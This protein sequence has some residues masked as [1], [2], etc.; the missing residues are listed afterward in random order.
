MITVKKGVCKIDGDLEEITA[1]ML[2][3]MKSLTELMREYPEISKFLITGDAQTI[4]DFVN[5][6]HKG[7]KVNL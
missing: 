4:T 3:T 7:V 2:V 5:E 1:E 6:I